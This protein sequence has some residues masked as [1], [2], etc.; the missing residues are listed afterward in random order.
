MYIQG[1]YLQQL[2][3]ENKEPIRPRIKEPRSSSSIWALRKTGS[4]YYLSLSL[5]NEI[6]S[7]VQVHM[8]A[9]CLTVQSMPFTPEFFL[10]HDEGRWS[11][12]VTP[13]NLTLSE[14][15]RILKQSVNK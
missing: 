3:H 5:K 14:K 4:Y 7:R 12:V 15:E 10:L 9:A 1:R 6:K 13:L 8:E 11:A 2:F